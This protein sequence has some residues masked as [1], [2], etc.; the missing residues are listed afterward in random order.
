MEAGPLRSVD[1]GALPFFSLIGTAA[2]EGVDDAAADFLACEGGAR[3]ARLVFALSF[4]AALC[5]AT[6]SPSPHSV[7]ASF[8]SAQNFGRLLRI[9]EEVADDHD[10]DAGTAAAAGV[11]V[12]AAALLSWSLLLLLILHVLACPAAAERLVRKPIAPFWSSCVEDGSSLS[13][14]TSIGFTCSDKWVILSFCWS[15]L[16]CSM[17]E[18]MRRAVRSLS[19]A[20]ATDS[21]AVVTD[22]VGV[23][24]SPPV[25][26]SL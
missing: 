8:T 22:V 6:S 25:G 13:G 21:P 1:G 17:T 26:T 18:S 24:A 2:S 16:A 15:D 9:H 23:L 11:L 3:A 14:S 5:A 7:P 4:F 20:A 19:V 12:G 10:T